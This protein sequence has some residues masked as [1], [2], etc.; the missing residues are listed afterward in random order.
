MNEFRKLDKLDDLKNCHEAKIKNDINQVFMNDNI[1]EYSKKIAKN[2]F[3]Y[4]DSFN[5]VLEKLL[6]QNQDSSK[7]LLVV[8]LNSLETW[9]ERFQQ[10]Y[11]LDPNF[12]MKTD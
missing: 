11:A 4:L 12:I 6:F 1:K 2:L 10:K 3:N 8:P 7:K 9:Y 5:Q